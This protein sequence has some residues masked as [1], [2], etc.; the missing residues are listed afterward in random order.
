MGYYDYKIKTRRTAI[1]QAIIEKTNDKVFGMLTPHL[2]PGAEVLDVGAGAGEFARRCL[3]AGYRYC[4]VEANREYA[5]ALRKQGAAEVITGFVPPIP[6]PEGRFDLVY[7]SHLLEHMPD[8]LKA[9]ELVQEL[10]RVIKPGGLVALVVPDFLHDPRLFFDADYT[11]G[12]VT[13]ENRARMLLLDAGFEL[14]RVRALAGPVTGLLGWVAAS[15][16]KLYSRWLYVPVSNLL[17]PWVNPMRLGKLRTA[18]CRS[19]FVLARKA[20]T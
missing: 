20:G 8:P 11:H 19:V 18:F 6:F 13:T 4:A 15:L 17:R 9:L 10:N 12:F 2:K 1:G 5:D 7:M 3:A 16:N 14:I